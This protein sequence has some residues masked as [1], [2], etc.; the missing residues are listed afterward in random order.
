MQLLFELLWRC[1]Y[2]LFQKRS[3]RAEVWERKHGKGRSLS[4][5]DLGEEESEN[6]GS[7]QITKDLLFHV[8]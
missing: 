8:R 7:V 2:S 3:R 5:T 6:V 4:E 1:V